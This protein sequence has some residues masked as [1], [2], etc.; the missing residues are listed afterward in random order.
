MCDKKTVRKCAVIFS[1]FFMT[2]YFIEILLNPGRATARSG[3][4]S[5]RPVFTTDC[6][7]GA[8]YQ[9]SSPAAQNDDGS[10]KAC[11]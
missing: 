10:G 5:R 7:I 2:L 4:T 6:L 3:Q 1:Q 9:D 8:V 11:M